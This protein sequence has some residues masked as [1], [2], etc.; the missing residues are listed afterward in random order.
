MTADDLEREFSPLGKVRGKTL[1]LR[2]RETSALVEQAKA[3]G[4]RVWGLD[5][6]ELSDH[7]TQPVIEKSLNLSARDDLDAAS[8][9]DVALA[10]LREHASE[11]LYC[12]VVLE[13]SAKA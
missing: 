1:Y 4:L 8:A 6:A 5:V 7:S 11:D 13:Q 10:F 9:C 3:N 12:E 2:P